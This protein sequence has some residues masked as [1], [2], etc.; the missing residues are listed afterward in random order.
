MIA[1]SLAFMIALSFTAKDD[2]QKVNKKLLLYRGF[3]R[4]FW[5]CAACIVRERVLTSRNY[6]LN[7]KLPNLGAV[8]EGG[9]K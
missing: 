5:H 2:T 1:L 8:M 9:E 3:S 6:L 4:V 7:N